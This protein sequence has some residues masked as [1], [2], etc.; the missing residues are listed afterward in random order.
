MTHI[1]TP[2]ASNRKDDLDEA[3]AGDQQYVLGM[4]TALNMA[5]Q[6]AGKLAHEIIEQREREIIGARQ[7]RRAGT[8]PI[9][10]RKGET[11]QDAIKRAAAPRPSPD[12]SGGAGER[13]AARV[14]LDR[15][16]V[17]LVIAGRVVFDRD[18]HPSDEVMRELDQALE[19][20]SSRVPYEE[21]PV[22][23]EAVD[24]AQ[25]AVE[26]AF[27][28]ACDEIGCAYDNEAL[29]TAI[30]NLKTSRPS[31]AGWDEAI[32]AAAMKAENF[33]RTGGRVRPSHKHV[34]AAIRAL[35]RPAPDA[36]L[37]EALAVALKDGGCTSPDSTFI[38]ANTKKVID[39]V[40]ATLS[41]PPALPAAKGSE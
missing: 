33:G 39:V 28:D 15:D 18:N 16:V 13:D 8:S 23:T 2:D 24:T 36:G 31:W 9:H 5:E 35:P 37:R 34:A 10:V 40:M 3:I 4:K 7:E 25:A 20:F 22:A 41:A 30:R 19:A 32:E 38:H 11:L 1:P 17:R 12:T 27:T 26:R 21:Q 6:G 14:G 29:L